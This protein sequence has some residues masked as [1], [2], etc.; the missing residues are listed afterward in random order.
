MFTATY[1]ESRARQK[2]LHRQADFDRLARTAAEGNPKASSRN[3][4]GFR[5]F[6]GTR[7][8]DRQGSPAAGFRVG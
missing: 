7:T 2:E 5:I 3:G 4:K 6:S 8:A 1:Q